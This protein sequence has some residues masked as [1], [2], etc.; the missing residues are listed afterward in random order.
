MADNL[1]NRVGIDGY[2][3][4]PKRK[5]EQGAGVAADKQTGSRPTN[6][7]SAS[8]SRKDHEISESESDDEEWDGIDV[9][10]EG[11]RLESMLWCTCDRCENLPTIRENLCC[12]ELTAVDE[13]LEGLACIC[14]NPDFI[15]LCTNFVN[16]RTALIARSDIRGDNLREPIDNA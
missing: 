5:R 9:E 10:T 3:F 11:W 12:K 8:A 14:Q 4:E 1:S 15:M 6:G 16:L 2:A 13:K 7:I